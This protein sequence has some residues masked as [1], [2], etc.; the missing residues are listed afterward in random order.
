MSRTIKTQRHDEGFV[1]PAGGAAH[2]P[3]EHRGRIHGSECLDWHP[4]SYRTG[5]CNALAA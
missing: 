3:E 2:K 4:K 1:R 5:Q